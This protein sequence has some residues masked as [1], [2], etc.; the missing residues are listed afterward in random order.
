MIIDISSSFAASLREAE[1]FRGFH[2]EL[3]VPTMALPAL[4]ARLGDLADWPDEG[5][6]WISIAALRRPSSFMVSA[7]STSICRRRSF[8]RS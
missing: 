1:N 3:D 4:R 5:V 8:I 7:C 6:A 2:V